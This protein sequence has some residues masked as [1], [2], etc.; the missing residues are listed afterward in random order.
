MS[1]DKA[2]WSYEVDQLEKVLKIIGAQLESR[3]NDV[4]GSREEII[5]TRKL[6]W[7]E[8]GH[9]GDQ[10]ISLDEAADIKH[11]ID[12]LRR[13]D[14]R[15]RYS[16]EMA[17]RLRRMLK[18]PYFARLDFLEDGMSCPDKMYI[19]I[20]T[21]TDDSSRDVVIYDWRA[22]VSSMFYDYE[23]GRAQYRCPGETVEGDIKLKRQFRIA[24]GKLSYMFDSSLKIDDEVLQELLSKSAD[25][26]MK[27]IVTSIQKEQN[28]IIRNEKNDLLIVQGAAGSGKTSIALHRIAFLLYRYRDQKL[29]SRNIVIF[30]PNTVF[31]D[32][33]SNVLPELGEEN[34]R[35]TTFFEYAEKFCREDLKLED[36]N[37]QMEYLLTAY[38]E[39]GYNARVEGIRFKSTESFLKILVRYM[40]YLENKW[41]RFKDVVYRD[42]VVFSKAEISG[43]FYEDFKHWPVNARLARIRER[44]LYQ[45]EPLQ[46]ERLEEVKLELLGNAEFEHRIGPLARYMTIKEF[47]PVR[48]EIYSMTSLDVYDAYCRLFED[49]ELFYSFAEDTELP[50]CIGDIMGVTLERLLSKKPGYEDLP[51]LLYMR[52]VLEG[53]PV[54]SDIKHLVIDEAQDYSPIQYEIFRQLFPGCGITMLGDLNQSISPYTGAC[55]Y[56]AIADVFGASTPTIIRLTKC[57]RSTSQIVEFTRAVLDTGEKVEPFGRYG[58][59]PQAIG[60]SMRYELYE[61]VEEGIKKLSEE[62]C[63]SVAVVCKTETESLEVFEKLKEKL[64]IVLLSSDDIYFKKGIVVIPAYLAKGLEFDAVIIFDAGIES[65]GIETERKLFYTACTRAMHRLHIYYSG[66][67]SPFISQVDGALYE[68][69]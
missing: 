40:D 20:S 50:V 4:E 31:N 60:V 19:G 69:R 59:K 67:L 56:D 53:V 41:L 63:K 64:E 26:K 10:P 35:Q 44:L 23:Q 21:L 42:R 3:K 6:M 1:V 45:L 34:M 15:Y 33:I 46:K 57:Y 11:Y 37:H 27:T 16:R 55:S 65:Y 2:E 36:F 48:E 66:M 61:A 30:S 17:K 62:G 12:E 39:S 51:P 14:L 54:L 38:A 13:E 49:E 22:P 25:D 47:Q 29:T 68:S 7:D 28:R 58:E 52:N 18:T 32:Y 9:V 43:M 8:V 24:E 5:E